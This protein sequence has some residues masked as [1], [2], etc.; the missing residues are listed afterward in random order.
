MKHINIPVFIPHL[1]CP[2]TCVFCNQ[3]KISGVSEFDIGSV[4]DKIEAVL[5]SERVSGAEIEIAFFGGS[6]TG[7]PRDQMVSLLEL[8]G[9]YLVSGDVKSLR[10]STRP[11]YIDEEIISIL[12]SHGMTTVELGIQSMSDQVLRLSKRGHTAEQSMRACRLIKE[13]GM[14][15]VGQMMTG[16]P[17]SSRED[18][19]HT[20]ECLCRAGADAA[21][22]YP[23]MVFAQ[24]ELEAMMNSDEYLPPDTEDTVERVADVLEVFG[25]HSIPV[26]RI[27]LC[28]SDD[29]ESDTG[30][31][32]GGYEPAIGEMAISRIFLRRMTEALGSPENVSDGSLRRESIHV[33]CPPRM[34]SAVFG[35]RSANRKALFRMYGIKK[36]TV[37]EDAALDVYNIKLCS[38]S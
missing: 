26:I 8:A 28:S 3:R 36:L 20:A 11:D 12:L 34:T 10:C 16:L 15:L 30:I 5:E 18:E 17:G 37:T 32:A 31:V 9:E 24:T 25:R 13:S 6:F 7:I 38:D 4:R 35:H 29:L 27:G 14:K 22:V 1:G 21:R 23:T 2:N 19:I 33:I